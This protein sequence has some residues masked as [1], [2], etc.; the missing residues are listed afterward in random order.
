MADEV[1]D[2][3]EPELWNRLKTQPYRAFVVMDALIDHYDR[4]QITGVRERNAD[5]TCEARARALGA[6]IKVRATAVGS[7]LPVHGTVLVVFFVSKN[8]DTKID[9][10][11]FAEQTTVPGRGTPRGGRS[12]RV[13]L[14]KR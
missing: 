2:F 8:N 13:Y 3:C 14:A 5:A 6:E 4:V 10:L 9:T 11:V 1:E 12:L 7:N